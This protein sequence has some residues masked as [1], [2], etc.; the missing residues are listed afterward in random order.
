[1]PVVLGFLPG[2]QVDVVVQSDPINIGGVTAD[3]QGCVPVTFQVPKDFDLGRHT[4]TF[5]GVTSGT[6][7]VT[8]SVATPTAGS[9][10]VK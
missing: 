2:E 8:F 10:Q 5:T 6:A 4:V 3:A 1:M 7:T 9:S